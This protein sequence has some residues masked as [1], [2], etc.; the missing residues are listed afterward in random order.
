MN[1]KTEYN[2]LKPETYKR[3]EECLENGRFL[4]EALKANFE[5]EPV[6]QH[7]KFGP[8]ANEKLLEVMSNH[9]EVYF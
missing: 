1:E 5:Y 6:F 2:G 9:G 3:L 4:G 8:K 7:P